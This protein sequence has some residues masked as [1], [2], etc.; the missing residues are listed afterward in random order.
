MRPPNRFAGLAFRGGAALLV[1]AI[2]YAVAFR[3]ANQQVDGFCAR[4]TRDTAVA[5][6]PAIARELHVKLQGP[7]VLADAGGSRVVAAVVNPLTLGDYG[8]T[9]DAPPLDGRVAGTRLGYRR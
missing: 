3:R 6:L 2:G 4:V 7:D 9:I 1:L 8:C 5:D